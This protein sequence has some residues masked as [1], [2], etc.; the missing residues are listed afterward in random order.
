MTNKGPRRAAT[1]G[2]W[3]GRL[4]QAREFQESARSLVRLADNKGYNG[5]ITL[6]IIAA[7]PGEHARPPGCVA[8]SARG[9]RER[10]A[11]QAGEV[12]P[13]GF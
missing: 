2:E 4:S 3:A 11:G 1:D 12:L 6:M 9:A 13:A 8:A 10:A 7:I 5:A